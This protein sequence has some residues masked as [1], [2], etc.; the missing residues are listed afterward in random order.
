MLNSCVSESPLFTAMTF[1]I[2]LKGYGFLS[3]CKM[4]LKFNFPVPLKWAWLGSTC[5]EP[6]S[7]PHV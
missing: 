1:Y 6:V 2:A 3:P 4:K 7:F 5:A